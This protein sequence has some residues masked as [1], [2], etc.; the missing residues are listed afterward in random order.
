MGLEG[1][2]PR[3]AGHTG[4]VSGNG[5]LA[6]RV[7]GGRK[8]HVARDGS[9]DILLRCWELNLGVWEESHVPIPCVTSSLQ[10]SQDLMGETVF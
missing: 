7:R 6:G 3:V 5:V 2:S 8:H 10:I 9:V 4:S 1:H